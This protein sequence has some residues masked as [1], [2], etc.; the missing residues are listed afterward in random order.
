MEIHA[1]HEAGHAYVATLLGGRV[2]LVS[3]E[4]E[5]DDGPRRSGETRVTWSRKLSDREVCERAIPV[6]LGGPVAEMLYT[7]DPYHPGCVAEW[8]QDWQMAWNQAATWLSDERE[9]VHLLERI[10]S[11]L[12]RQL[13][14]EPH[15]SAVAALADHLLA[16][17]TL[18]GPEVREILSEWV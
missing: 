11:E 17:E 10:T 18:E 6:A 13:D 9:R 3:I 16:H 1:Y 12:Y 14:S 8:L 7:G 15:W 5:D 2:T 4:P